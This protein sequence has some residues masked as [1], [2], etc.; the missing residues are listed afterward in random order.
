MR[1]TFVSV[2]EPTCSKSWCAWRVYLLETHVQYIVCIRIAGSNAVF[3]GGLL[4]GLVEC[5]RKI[6]GLSSRLRRR[7]VSWYKLVPGKSG[8]LWYLYSSFRLEISAD[9]N[10]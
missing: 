5:G 8:E 1:S 10:R 9:T 3:A 4:I 7:D 2:V 6:G